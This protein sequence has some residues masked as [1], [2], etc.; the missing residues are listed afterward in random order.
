[1]KTSHIA[2]LFL[3]SA[4]VFVGGCA[5]TQKLNPISTPTVSSTGESVESTAVSSTADE[6]DTSTWKTYKMRRW[7][8]K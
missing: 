2:S 3:L 5:L 6:V 8:L 4:T 7:G 1:M